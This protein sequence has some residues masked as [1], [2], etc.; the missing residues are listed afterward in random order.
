METKKILKEL[1]KHYTDQF[2]INVLCKFIE[3]FQDSFNEYLPTEEVIKRL[4]DRVCKIVLSKDLIDDKLD[5][6][7]DDETKTVIICKSIL[8]QTQYCNNVIFHELL[9][10]ITTKD[11]P[12][13]TRMFGFYNLKSKK[14]NWFNEAITEWLT[15]TRNHEQDVYFVSGYD[16]I[17]EQI[18]IL[19]QIIGK[20]KL[21]T[22]F[23]YDPEN[24]RD[25]LN[26]YKIDFDEIEEIFGTLVQKEPDI[27][28]L[29]NQQKLDNSNNVALYKSSEKL[30]DIYSNAIGPIDSVEKFKSK[31]QT[32]RN[33][34]N[35]NLN[36]TKLIEVHFYSSMYNDLL[37]IARNGASRDEINKVLKDM[38]IP[39]STIRINHYFNEVFTKDKKE[40]AI[41]LHKF[42]SQNP[43]QYYRFA[44]QNYPLLSDE[45]SETDLL[46]NKNILY[47]VTKYP[48]IGKFLLDHDT[49]EY[50]E[51][52]TTKMATSN[53]IVVYVF[54][55]SDNKRFLYTLPSFPVELIGD[56]KFKVNYGNG[57]ITF[58]FQN[59]TSF[60]SKSK[61]EK[62]IVA[63]GVYTEYSQLEDL[64]YCINMEE[65]DEGKKDMYKQKADKIRKKIQDN[66][67]RIK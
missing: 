65:L 6:K 50:E 64:D 60:K 32:L 7:Y 51:I 56:N 18:F 26:E 29:A 42:F 11:L 40:K 46:P 37:T 43:D 8:K 20:D 53:G 38:G 54:K 63:N 24:I 4:K 15:K 39:Y 36:L 47:D 13:N 34:R 23:L 66:E 12:D 67:N 9:H 14:G 1:E 2:T 22:T 52:S 31:Y 35:N 21:I 62:P 55:T 16:A 3:D 10:A 27:T 49:Y 57:D 5:G 45:F 58:N 59:G 19:S 25:L 48:M 17:S 61:V 44:H 41:A 33:Y 30:F 28:H